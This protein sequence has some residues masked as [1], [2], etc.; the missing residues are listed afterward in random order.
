[1][2]PN[3]RA[4]AQLEELALLLLVPAALHMGWQVL[5]LRLDAP[6][7]CLR[8]FRSNRDTGLLIA[9]GLVLAC[10]MR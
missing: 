9:A 10:Y 5:T 4:E 7:I 2:S 3:S 8:L 1:M 6:D